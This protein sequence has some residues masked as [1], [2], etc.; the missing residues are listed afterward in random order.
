M[1][2]IE[3]TS[4]SVLAKGDAIIDKLEKAMLAD[5]LVEC[6][7]VNLAEESHYRKCRQV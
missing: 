7:E 1:A 3:I 2:E 6:R 5:K 4:T